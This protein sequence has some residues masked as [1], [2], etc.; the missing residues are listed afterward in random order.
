MAFKPQHA[1]VR[2]NEVYWIPAVVY[3][4][5]NGYYS[6]KRSHAFPKGGIVPPWNVMLIVPPKKKNLQFTMG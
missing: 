3:P 5:P 6:L 4:L 2:Y 1:R